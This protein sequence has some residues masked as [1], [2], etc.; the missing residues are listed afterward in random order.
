QSLQE[1]AT[2]TIVG[3]EPEQSELLSFRAWLSR[4][5]ELRGRVRMMQPQP[6]PGQMGA[7]ANAVAVSLAAEAVPTFGRTLLTWIQTRDV[8]VRV[9]IA[10]SRGDRVELSSSTLR[11]H[12]ERVARD[13]I[14][15]LSEPALVQRRHLPSTHRQPNSGESGETGPTS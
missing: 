14:A 15:Q 4:E 12:G 9:V 8:E 10:N 5:P 6:R 7:A 1:D 2:V 11:L 3:D 13:L